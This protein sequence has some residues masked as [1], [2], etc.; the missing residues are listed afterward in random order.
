MRL[1]DWDRGTSGRRELSNSGRVV[2]EPREKE[3]VS[4]TLVAAGDL[5][6]DTREVKNS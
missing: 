5:A 3:Q 6:Q 1:Q 4:L 2:K